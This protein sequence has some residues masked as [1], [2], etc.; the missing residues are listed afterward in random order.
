MFDC[1]GCFNVCGDDTL[2]SAA[3]IGS[4]PIIGKMGKGV[5]MSVTTCLD[6][7]F[8]SKVRCAWVKQ[9]LG[10][11]GTDKEEGRERITLWAV[12]R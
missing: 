9:S 7:E 1:P 10:T 2:G 6:N 4:G 5:V 12:P 11:L 8:N 3:I